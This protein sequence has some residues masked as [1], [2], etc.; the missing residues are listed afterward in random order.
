MRESKFRAWTKNGIMQYN[1]VPFEWDYVIDKMWHRCIESNGKGFLGSGGTEAKFE[2]GGFAIEEGNLMQ[3]T[4]LK[5]KNSKEIY[6]G[7][8]VFETGY[9][10]NEIK[11]L[12]DIAAFGYETNTGLRPIPLAFC[13]TI[14]GNI[15]E[16]HDLL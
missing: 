15:Y 13:C 5:D 16:N 2:V 7:D 10:N 3:F 14:I 11:W 4:G 9:G 8:I 1:I 12:N 6:E